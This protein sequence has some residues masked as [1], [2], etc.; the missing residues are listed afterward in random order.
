MSHTENFSISFT[1]KLSFFPLSQRQKKES[2]RCLEDGKIEETSRLLGN[3]PHLDRQNSIFI[4]YIIENRNWIDGSVI[5]QGK[6]HLW[7]LVLKTRQNKQK[8]KYQFQCVMLTMG[9]AFYSVH[10]N[11]K[12]ILFLLKTTWPWE[13]PDK[14]LHVVL[15]GFQGVDG[16]SVIR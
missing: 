15:S 12:L 5:R 11:L 14:V 3:A 6:T 9:E 1:K 2:N 10:W 8:S 13:N 4:S 16:D 7:D